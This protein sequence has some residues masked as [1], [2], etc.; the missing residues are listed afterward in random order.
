MPS[1]ANIRRS[2]CLPKV[3]LWQISNQDICKLE[4]L[5]RAVSACSFAAALSLLH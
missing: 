5:Q 3:K 1:Q 4:R 2:S